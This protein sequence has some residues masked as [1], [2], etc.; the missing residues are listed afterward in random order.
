MVVGV[1]AWGL[2]FGGFARTPNDTTP[3]SNSNTVGLSGSLAIK[4][5]KIEIDNYTANAVASFTLP[6]ENGTNRTAE[7]T[8]IC[9]QPDQ[10]LSGYIKGTKTSKEWFGIEAEHLTLE[11]GATKDVQI[12]FQIPADVTEDDFIVYSL[13]DEGKQ[14]LENARASTID[15]E[16][17]LAAAFKEQL[18]GY[19]DVYSEF[20]SIYANRGDKYVF[21][22]IMDAFP[23]YYPEPLVSAWANATASVQANLS[24]VPYAEGLAILERLGSVSKREATDYPELSGIPDTYMARA[25]LRTQPWEMWVTVTSGGPPIQVELA[26]RV[27][28]HM[29]G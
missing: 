1:L 24:S 2:G 21:K 22:A 4:V 14:Y 9:R 19:Q 5:G 18:K 26:C 23:K 17:A 20:D 29:A 13:T 8:V 28:I 12:S 27:L 10:P 7:C 11:P 3:S 16:D 15:S 25:D 6:I